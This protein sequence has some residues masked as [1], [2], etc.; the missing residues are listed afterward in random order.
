MCFSNGEG[1]GRGLLH[2]GAFFYSSSSIHLPLTNPQCTPAVRVPAVG[3]RI[4]SDPNGHG[5]CSLGA[6]GLLLQ[7]GGEVRTES[8]DTH[9]EQV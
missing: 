1:P 3:V 8:R 5:S 7:W 9:T 4:T 2:Q 6:L